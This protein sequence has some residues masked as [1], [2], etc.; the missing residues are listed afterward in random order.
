MTLNHT[1]GFGRREGKRTGEKK[2]VVCCYLIWTRQGACLGSNLGTTGG[3]HAGTQDG[4][5]PASHLHPQ[6]R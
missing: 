6:L 4:S 3:C 5:G 2:N 1:D